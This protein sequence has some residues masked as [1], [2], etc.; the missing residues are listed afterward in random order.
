MSDS[1]GVIVERY[2]YDAFGNTTIYSGSGADGTWFTSDDT[3]KL[4]PGSAYGNPY[5]F[6]A[7]R[8]DAQTGLYYYRAR[9]YNPK[10]GRF[11]QPDPIGYGDGMNMYTYCGN[12]PV[13]FVDPLGLSKEGCERSWWQ[14]FCDWFWGNA[15]QEIAEEAVEQAAEKFV[16]ND[17]DLSSAGESLQVA[18]KMGLIDSADVAKDVA[19]AGRKAGRKAAKNAAEK[20]AKKAKRKASKALKNKDFSN[21]FHN[22]YKLKQKISGGKGIKNPDMD[23][24]EVLEALEEW[25]RNGRPKR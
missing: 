8:M 24:E 23:P 19:K 12:N 7:R 16:V 1:S 4:T 17:G 20:A 15:P 10:T 9:M 22:K 25:I 6:T 14:K 18:A 5:M 13:N 11:L 2:G 3:V 21:Y